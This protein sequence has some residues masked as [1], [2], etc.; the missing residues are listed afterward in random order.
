MVKK[1]CFFLFLS[2]ECTRSMMEM[3]RKINQFT[4]LN[5][6]LKSELN[7]REKRKIWFPS[8]RLVFGSCAAIQ[9]ICMKSPAN[10]I[11]ER[12]KSEYTPYWILVLVCNLLKAVC[13]APWMYFS[14]IDWFPQFVSILWIQ[15]QKRRRYNIIPVICIH[16]GKF[17]YS[18]FFILEGWVKKRPNQFFIISLKVLS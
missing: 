14:L 2:V 4:G 5:D 18:L 12:L 6:V 10:S 13:K 7:K 3:G 8:R 15:C 9:M 11:T 17:A 1:P 16:W